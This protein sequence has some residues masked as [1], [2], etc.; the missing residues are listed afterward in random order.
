MRGATTKN[1]RKK[2]HL[3]ISTHAPLAGRDYYGLVWRHVFCHFNPRAPCGA[4]PFLNMAKD[5]LSLIS[6][7]APL[8]GRDLPDDRRG[9]VA[10]G[11]QPTRPLR[12]ATSSP[13]PAWSRFRHFNPRAP[14]GA[15]RDGCG[16]P[17][18][19]LAISTHAPL[20][21]RDRFLEAAV[22]GEANHFNPRAPCGARLKEVDDGVDR[23]AISTHAPLAGRDQTGQL[24]VLG[25]DI[26]T[27]APLAGRDYPPPVRPAARRNF[28]P[29]APC[30]ARRGR[31][32][33]RSPIGR[34]F[35]P[36][37]PCGAR[38]CSS[39]AMFTS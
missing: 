39:L 15:R 3:K 21:G 18:A 29:R 37:A 14:C 24:R 26:S 38:L 1:E 27:H 36:R 23:I 7:H 33:R 28:N 30:G 13:R 25:L 35:N 17:E 4:R 19:Y 22:L 31:R 16:E 6:T 2:Q 20:A 12:G 11:F 9:E 34:Y 5:Y 10:V 32:C 8:A